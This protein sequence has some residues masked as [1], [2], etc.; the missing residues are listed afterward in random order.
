MPICSKCGESFP[1]RITINGKERTLN[2]RKYCLNCSP[3]GLHNTKKLVESFLPK[4][5]LCSKCGE[6]NPTMFYQNHNTIC[7]SCKNIETYKL[8]KKKRKFAIDKLGGKCVICGFNK[9]E[10]AL[11]IH[12]VNPET[13]DSNFSSMRHWSY[14]RILHEIKDCVL[15]CKN[16][17]AALHHGDLKQEVIGLSPVA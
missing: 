4:N 15:L 5:F 3:F 6:T 13:K 9:Y 10:C 17:H 1:N 2:K 7:K 11:D 14:N 16:C 8:S 12:H